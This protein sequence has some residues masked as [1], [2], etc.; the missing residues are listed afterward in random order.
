MR[1]RIIHRQEGTTHPRLS[2]TFGPVR[3][4]PSG[5]HSTPLRPPE[6][7]FGCG[8]LLPVPTAFQVM[9]LTSRTSA[10]TTRDNT[11]LNPL[12]VAA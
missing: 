4:D 10:N 1:H 6:H 11:L 2:Q 8:A 12:G 9:L 3:A 5:D 7:G